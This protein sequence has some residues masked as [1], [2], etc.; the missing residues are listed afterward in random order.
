MRSYW[1]RTTNSTLQ[2]SHWADVLDYETPQQR[3]S[4]DCGVF[5][6]KMAELYTRTGRVLFDATHIDTV[7]KRIV[8]ELADGHLHDS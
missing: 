1:D 7:R 6:L 2:M 4:L 8:T 3:N 5:L